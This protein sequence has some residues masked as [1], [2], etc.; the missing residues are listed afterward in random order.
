MPVPTTINGTAVNGATPYRVIFPIDSSF[1]NEADLQLQPR[2]GYVPQI[3]GSQVKERSITFQV[4]PGTTGVPVSNHQWYQNVFGIFVPDGRQKSIRASW[5]SQTIELFGTIT[6]IGPLPGSPLTDDDDSVI[7]G[8]FRIVDPV[9]REISAETADASSPLTVSRGN[10][11][12]QPTVTITPTT[13]TVRHRIVTI[14][15]VLGTGLSNYPIIAQF[16]SSTGSPGATA[17]SNYIAFFNQREIP[18]TVA[19][20]NTTT[21]RVLFRVNC[22]PG[23]SVQVHLYY[24]SSVSNILTSS[25][26]DPMGMA[27]TDPDISNTH[28]IWDSFVSTLNGRNISGV[29]TPLIL[30]TV[31][32]I[33][34]TAESSSQ[35][36]YTVTTGATGVNPHAVRMVIGGSVAGTSNALT[37]LSRQFNDILGTPAGAGFIDFQAL[38]VLGLTNAWLLAGDNV[39]VTTAVDVDNASAIFFGVRNNGGATSNIITFA[40]SGDFALDLASTPSVNVS[41]ATT[42]RFVNSTL[43]NTTTG[44]AIQF[45]TLY[46]DD[47]TLIIDCLN[48]T[49]ST[50]NGTV[51][52]RR[53]IRF[54]NKE[55]WMTLNVGSNAWTNATNTTTSFSWKPSYLL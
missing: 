2:E 51:F 48:K 1:L 53:G 22:D 27:I 52:H 55:R 29:W 7:E 54:S 49:I 36:Q 31:V 17:S 38:G 44:D 45:D 32:P 24:G 30:D 25:A 15:D 35:R 37:G 6:R 23:G 11:P 46:M 10:T 33:V 14:T 16:D 47:T 41:A 43:T 5:R 50:G 26:L 13:T 18:I 34:S 8:D 19:S 39:T 4:T 40:A 42:A 21:T 9:W 28:W 3:V 12:A 20:P